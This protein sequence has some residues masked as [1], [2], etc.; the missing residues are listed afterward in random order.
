[1]YKIT[2]LDKFN[3]KNLLL[4]KSSWLKK[5]EFLIG[6]TKVLD[7]SNYELADFINKVIDTLE[8]EI[9]NLRNDNQENTIKYCKKLIIRLF[10]SD[11]EEKIDTKNKWDQI[12]ELSNIHPEIYSHIQKLFNDWHYFSAVEEA[13]KISRNKLMKLTWKERASDAFSEWNIEKIFWKQAENWVEKDFFE[14]VKFLHY[15][16]QY[17]RNEKAHTPA[18]EL[19]K[20][21]AIHYIYLA[22]LALYL[23]DD[24]K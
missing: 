14:W 17:F 11:N 7:M 12:N 8:S 16:I 15:S 20:N 6:Y 9:L 23:I 10:D 1:M 21:R 18:K 2:E 3:I 5:E 13:Y 4:L 24:K 22:S 19:D